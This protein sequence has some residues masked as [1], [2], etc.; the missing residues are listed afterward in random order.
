MLQALHRAAWQM[1][2]CSPKTPKT[3]PAW[4]QRKNTAKNVLHA[5]LYCRSN[6]LLLIH[7]KAYLL[8]QLPSFHVLH[9]RGENKATV[10]AVVSSDFTACRC[11]NLMCTQFWLP[12]AA[13]SV[14]DS[15]ANCVE[16]STY[17]R[18]A[19][20]TDKL[21]YVPMAQ[22]TRRIVFTST[23]TKWAAITPWAQPGRDIPAS[24]RLSLRS[25]QTLSQ[26][27]AGTR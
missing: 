4:V 13:G 20:S 11:Q 18:K 5:F 12:S 23:N 15:V 17:H 26:W 3:H 16:I 27:E 7:Q 9:P 14:Q 10:F 1:A 24:S 22:N 2:S 21:Y 19:V 25:R 6:R 8:V